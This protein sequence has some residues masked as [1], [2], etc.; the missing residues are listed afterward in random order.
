MRLFQRHFVRRAGTVGL[1]R[2]VGL[3]QPV[4]LACLVGQFPAHLAGQGRRGAGRD[5]ASA[6]RWLLLHPRRDALRRR[7]RLSVA[8]RT[9][10]G[11]K[12]VAS[13]TV[14]VTARVLMADVVL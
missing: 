14:S 3:V 10:S 6:D 4:K 5:D 8:A 12:S 11:L 13:L 2:P 7:P 1:I 9:D